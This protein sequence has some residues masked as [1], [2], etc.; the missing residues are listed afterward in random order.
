[1][2]YSSTSKIDST[3]DK[4]P[5]R[6]LFWIR[7][8]S[9]ASKQ[10][11]YFLL[12]RDRLLSYNLAVGVDFG[13]KAMKN[14]PVFLTKSYY[15]V[16]LDADA[17]AKG[18]ETYPDAN[19]VHA[20]I[21]TADVPPADFAICVNVIGGTNFKNST[22]QD[23]LRSMVDKIA[24]GGTLLVTV[25][26]KNNRPGYLEECREVLK[27]SFERVDETPIPF[28]IKRRGKRQAFVRALRY[29]IF[30]TSEARADR[31]YCRCKGRL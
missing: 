13:C 12:M 6:R 28:G 26:Q 2:S 29:L 17:L 14:R 3:Q 21:E 15:G 31:M 8:S 24:P 9:K 30:G 23:V 1:M 5:A 10:L 4:V 20:T 18:V 19:S 16:D 22:A 11:V 25:K 27:G 7:L